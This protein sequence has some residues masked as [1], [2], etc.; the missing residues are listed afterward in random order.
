MRKLLWLTLALHLC[1]ASPVLAEIKPETFSISPYI[2]GYTFD[3]VQHLETRPVYGVRAGYDFTKHFGAEAVFDYVFT[4]STLAD[5]DVSVYN[6]RLDALYHFFPEQRLVPYLA[7]G[8]GGITVDEPAT[9]TTRGAFNYGGGLKFFLT[10]AMALRGD[11]RHFITSRDQTL[12]N[13]EY[14]VGLSFLFGGEKPAPA[15]VAKPAPAPAPE[16][17][18]VVKPA[19][20]PAPPPPPAPMATLAVTPASLVKGQTTTLSWSSQNATSCT[21]QPEIGPVQPSGSMVVTP[22]ADTAYTITCTGAGGSTTSTANAT[23]TTPVPKQAPKQE[24]LCITLAVEFATGKADIL[25]KYHD[26]IGKVAEFMKTY[27]DAKGVI[28]G[29]TDNVGGK[30]YNLKLSQRRAD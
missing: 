1:L 15:P 26:E 11:V 8:Y 9:A 19:P 4:T 21:I 20:A 29:H 12:H 16:P 28:E 14:T 22:A 23:V 5:T 27:P 6:Y 25:P 13:I 17:A 7:A 3:G 2:G 24:K 10:E 30:D 18:P